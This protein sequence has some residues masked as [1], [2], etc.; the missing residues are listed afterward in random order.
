MN[1]NNRFINDKG[2]SESTSFT[3]LLSDDDSSDTLDINIIKHSPYYSESD[4]HNQQFKK[5]NFSMLSLNCQSINAKFDEV[6][7][8]M[9]RINRIAEVSVLCLQETW[10]SDRDDISLFQLSHYKLL[11]RGK[12][13]CK[14]GGLFIYVH[15]RFNVE[16]LNLAFTCTN[17]KDTVL[18]Y[19]KQNRSSNTIL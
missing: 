16:S 14:H 9:D 8:F 11:H 4:F 15:D 3:H 7:L 12:Q 1:N 19:H 13:C 6:Q 17:R 18:K 5:G 10:I 2:L